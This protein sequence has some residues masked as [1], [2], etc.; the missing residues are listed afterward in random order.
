[1]PGASLIFSLAALALRIFFATRFPSL[2]VTSFPLEIVGDKGRGRRTLT[3]SRDWVP[4]DTL[5]LF[6]RPRSKNASITVI[7]SLSA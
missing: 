1:M 4:N 7:L 2:F 5:L 6:R 3:R